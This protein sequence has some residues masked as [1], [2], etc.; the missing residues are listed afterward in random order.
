MVVLGSL[1]ASTQGL[2]T[3]RITVTLTDDSGAVTPVA[4]HAL[5]ISDEPQTTPTRRIFTTLAGTAEVSLRPGQ[6]V[7]ESDQPVTFQGKTYE[8]SR[9]LEV[10]AAQATA[11]ALTTSNATLGAATGTTGTSPSASTAETDPSLLAARWRDAVVGLWTPSRHASGFVV[12]AR[13]LIVTSQRAIGEASSVDAR[14]APAVGVRATV[15]ASDAE[16]DVAILWVHPSAVSSLAPVPIGCGQSRPAVTHGQELY[17]VGVDLTGARHLTPGDVT[18][19]GPRLILSSLRLRRGN[20]GGPVFGVAGPIGFTTLDV[21]DSATDT[22]TRVIRLD[23]ACDVLAGAQQK[24]SGSMPPD[25]ARLPPDP[26]PVAAG[27]LAEAVKARAGDLSPYL[28]STRDFDVAFITPVHVYGAKGRT[29]TVAMD[30]GNWSEYVAEYPRALLV[31][32]TPK[33][34]EPLWAK[35]ARGAAMTQGMALPAMKRAKASFLRLRASCGET[36]VPPVHPFV[37]EHPV[38]SAEAIAEGLYVFEPSSLSPTCS[39][40][41]LTLYS[42]AQPGRGDVHAVD[43]KLVQQ[44]ARDFAAL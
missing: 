11:L 9:R 28:M 17:A 23:V 38:S 31:R 18:G 22:D 1:S 27:V 4:R 44:I 16:R 30:F 19:V 24:M 39:A 41:T 3:L 12:D 10:A 37:V 15:L 2:S 34:S 42:E 21:G 25:G 6:Y 20:P 14:I 33:R 5:L 13:G 26:K 32:V 43:P 40:V 29:A 36:D 7:V 35:L 8:W